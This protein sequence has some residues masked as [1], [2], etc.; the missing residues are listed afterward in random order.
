VSLSNSV[1]AFTDPFHDSSFCMYEPDRIVHVESERFTREKYETINPVLVFCD[2]FPDRIDRFHN[3][4]F[5]ESDIA[6]APFIKE[7]MALKR[8]HGEAA[9][10]FL[11]RRP[12][13]MYDVNDSPT[14]PAVRNDTDAV[15][16]FLRHLSRDDVTVF[17]CGHHAS[18]AANSFFSSGY[19]SAL[20]VT[21]D[22]I[23]CDY[24]LDEGGRGVTRSGE[25][26]GTRRIHGSVSRCAGSSISPVH[27]E[28]GCSFGFAW[29]RVTEHVLGR[30]VGEEGTAMAMAAFGDPV[31]FEHLLD[32]ERLWLPSPD[33]ELPAVQRTS[34]VSFMAELRDRFCTEQDGFDIAAALQ[35]VTE[36]RLRSF[37]SQFVR[38]D[39]RDLCLGGG[40]FLNCQAVGKL[41]GWFPQLR[42]IFVAPAPYDGGI[43]I[44]AAQLVHHCQLDGA[45]P[46][47]HEGLA[48]FALGPHFSR[49]QVLGACRSARAGISE[50]GPLDV[51]KLV[52]QGNV[53]GLFSGSAES[54]RRALGHRSIIADPR[55]GEMKARLNEQ[56][57]H[58]QWFRPFAPMVLAERVAEWFEVEPGFSSPYMSFAVPVRQPL[59][60]RI[61]AV[62]HADGS[63]RVQTVHRQLTPGLH[64]LVRAW[65]EM[66][67]VPVLLNTSF[68]E[69]EPIVETPSDA[70]NTM[71]RSGID[72]VYFVDIGVFARPEQ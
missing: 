51:L 29:A 13:Y 50:V 18:H 57:K 56:I 10:K 45:G 7:L 20:T 44:G 12:P 17:F 33:G 19:S 1:L 8:Q 38:A 70:L 37:L 28:T 43:S 41:H 72:G 52:E 24:R 14:C 46:T 71:R 68:N 66:T 35:A 5:E 39:D 9:F 27:Q 15:E 21:L 53:V 54:G 58:R 32:D 30:G 22:G 16:A 55:R 4:A 23:G 47:W 36:T 48:P 69:K 61:P 42:R 11:R 34:L 3:I 26:V 64:E 60:E 2:M 25:V 31:R 40:F 62:V 63:A 59:R 6:V 49:L 67:G 65:D